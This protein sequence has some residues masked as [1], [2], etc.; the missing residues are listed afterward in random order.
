MD[1]TSFPKSPLSKQ[2]NK[3]PFFCENYFVQNFGEGK[4]YPTVLDKMAI[5]T[6]VSAQVSANVFFTIQ[7]AETNSMQSYDKKPWQKTTRTQLHICP[8]YF[9]ID[10]LDYC[11]QRRDYLIIS[12]IS[13]LNVIFFLRHKGTVQLN[14]NINNKKMPK[15]NKSISEI[16]NT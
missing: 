14:R 3:S 5:Q 11:H 16:N 1:D 12:V 4:I 7:P 2:W 10:I 9:K 13:H 15:I 6:V 8:K